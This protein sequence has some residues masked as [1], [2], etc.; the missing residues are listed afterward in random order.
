MKTLLAATLLALTTLASGCLGCSAF[1]GGGDRVLAR[2]NDAIILCENAGFIA[3]TAGGVTEGT[4]T[5][6]ADGSITATRG[7][8]ASTAFV[9]TWSGDGTAATT[10][11]CEGNWTQRE[12]NATELDHADIQC[13]DLASRSWWSQPQL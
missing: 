11:L 10:D 9:L 13:Q 8:T 12:M 6:A 5:T 2:N 3:T 1:S 7:D 4:Y